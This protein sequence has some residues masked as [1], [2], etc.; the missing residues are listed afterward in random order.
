M[1][2][3]TPFLRLFLLLISG[4]LNDFSVLSEKVEVTVN[5]LWPC[6]RSVKLILFDSRL[7]WSVGLR[8]TLTGLTVQ[9]QGPK[10]ALGINNKNLFNYFDIKKLNWHPTVGNYLVI[11]VKTARFFTFLA[12][13]S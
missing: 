3:N 12:S 1:P 8:L 9:H 2:T 5:D 6:L 11:N 4:E 13:G 7:L 10:R